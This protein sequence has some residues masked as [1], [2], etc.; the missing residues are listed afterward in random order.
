M[1]IRGTC[2][3]AFSSRR[4]SFCSDFNWGLISGAI[5]FAV[6]VSG[7]ALAN[8]NLEFSNQAAR[9]SCEKMKGQSSES[10]AQSAT[11]AYSAVCASELYEAV[12]KNN[13]AGKFRVHDLQIFQ[14]RINERINGSQACLDNIDKDIATLD[15]K[16][17]P[18]IKVF[19]T[20]F[21]SFAH[22][23]L[24]N[25]KLEGINS[26]VFEPYTHEIKFDK[27]QEYISLRDKGDEIQDVLGESPGAD[28]ISQEPAEGVVKYRDEFKDIGGGKKYVKTEREVIGGDAIA[29]NAS[30]SAV[31]SYAL[32][33]C[34]DEIARQVDQVMQNLVGAQLEALIKNPEFKDVQTTVQLANQCVAITNLVE[35][36]LVNCAI[37][38]NEKQVLGEKSEDTS[39]IKKVAVN[40]KNEAVPPIIHDAAVGTKELKEKVESAPIER[41]GPAQVQLQEYT[42]AQ[43]RFLD[44]TKARFDAV[45]RYMDGRTRTQ[46]S[47][48]VHDPKAPTNG[49]PSK[50]AENNTDWLPIAAA[51]LPIV[52]GLAFSQVKKPSNPQSKGASIAPPK[53]DK[54]GTGVAANQTGN[55]DNK[56]NVGGNDTSS[57]GGNIHSGGSN[58]PFTMGASVSGFG[59][60][61][62]KPLSTGASSSDGSGLT[63]SKTAADKKDGAIA[64]TLAPKSVATYEGGGGRRLGGMSLSGSEADKSI[65][66]ML[67]ELLGKDK[68]GSEKSDSPTGAIGGRTLAS[69]R[70]GATAQLEEG[71]DSIS[72]WQRIRSAMST[73]L[74]KGN[75]AGPPQSF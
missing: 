60:E 35:T 46:E 74:S 72:L 24:D 75:L 62:A 50:I 20:K 3:S 47:A 10:I 65:N 70:K 73:Q 37:Y 66:D 53:F 5:A 43:Q 48:P 49:R 17:D 8:H 9:A 71:V 29:E 56:S 67:N 64:N 1:T 7:S 28:P 45:A 2:S 63:A 23:G 15:G 12:T 18:R 51:G 52:A 19:L 41:G 42:S 14:K 54:L 68:D 26:P 44:A 36:K 21:S 69:N 6:L 33:L 4:W 13:N 25:L 61:K 11:R 16:S 38:E 59:S 55:P 34:T 32:A 22:A 30:N 57:P 31:F 39:D 58:S 27:L 40:V